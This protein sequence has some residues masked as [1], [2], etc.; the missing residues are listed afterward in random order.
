LRSIVDVVR[1]ARLWHGRFHRRYQS[2]LCGEG[3]PTVVDGLAK[4][5]DPIDHDMVIVNL[6]NLGIHRLSSAA[7]PAPTPCSA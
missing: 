2:L 5:G 7:S 4:N 6:A 1:A 3:C